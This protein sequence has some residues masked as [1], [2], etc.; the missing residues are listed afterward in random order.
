MRKIERPFNVLPTEMKELYGIR[1]DI[2]ERSIDKWLR[3]VPDESRI[4][5]YG[6]C[7]TAENKICCK[8]KW[9]NVVLGTCR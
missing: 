7:L 3:L 9:Q 2:F 4:E 1:T 6:I 5:N 8:R